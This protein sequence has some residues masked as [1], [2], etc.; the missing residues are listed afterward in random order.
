MEPEGREDEAERGPMVSGMPYHKRLWGE[1]ALLK[2]KARK[3]LV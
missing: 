1:T 2:I 3:R